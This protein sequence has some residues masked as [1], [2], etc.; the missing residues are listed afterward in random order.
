M[1]FSLSAT[2]S[3]VKFN[4]RTLLTWYLKSCAENGGQ[5]PPDINPFLLWKMSV[6]K[7]RELAID[8]KDTSARSYFATLPSP[9]RP[10]RKAHIHDQE[11]DVFPREEDR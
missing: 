11:F 5:V 6:E 1:L 4:V 3:L 9:E 7:R 10:I 8:P 2:L